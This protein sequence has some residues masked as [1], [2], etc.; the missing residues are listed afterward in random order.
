MRKLTLILW[1]AMMLA[2]AVSWSLQAQEVIA[3]IRGTVTDPSGAGIPGATVKATNT[4]TQ[5]STTVPSMDDGGFEFLSLTPGIYDVT[6]TKDGFRTFT[7]NKIT[8][9]L[10]QIYNLAVPM[11]VGQITESVQVE[12]N[13]AQVESTVTQL[14]TLITAQ[15]IV[16][17]PLIGRNWTTLE[18]LAP[19]V[20]ASSDRF[21][22]GAYATNG[23]QT[24]QNSFLIDGADSN[25]IAINTPLVIPSPD[26]I[27]EF[28]LVS[29]TMN[30][31]YGRNSGGILNAIIKSGTN[32]FHGSAFE[33]FRDTSLNDP[34]F[35]NQPNVFHQNEFGGTI[36]GPI[37]KDKT[38]FFLSYQ[39]Y[40]NREAQSLPGG[41][42]PTVFTQAQRNGSFPDIANSTT[43]SPIA[44]VA[45]SGATMAAGTPYNVL[46]PNGQI[47]AADF[48]AISANLLQKYVPLPN[49][50]GNLY[51]YSPVSTNSDYQGIAKVDQ[52]FGSKD[53]VWASAFFEDNP[54]ADTLS[55]GGGNLP[56][57]GDV[58]KFAL[59]T[60]AASWSHVFS[61]T[62][63]NEFRASYVRE[64]F[65]SGEPQSSVLPS[66]LGFTGINPQDPA[67]AGVPFVGITG[68][69]NLGFGIQGPVPRVDENYQLNESVSKVM[70]NHTLKFGFTGERFG[71]AE[72]FDFINNGYYTFG[73]AGLYST[74]DP[75]ADFLLGIPDSYEQTSG[76]TQKERAYEYY[77]FVQDSWKATRSLTLNYGLGYQIDTP[78]NN[79]WDGGLA[80]DCLRPGQQST[81]FPSAPVGLVF[82][83][84]PT[85]SS[86]GYYSHYDNFAPRF[87]FA[88]SPNWGPIS[89]GKAQ[90]FVIRGG[91]GISFNQAEEETALQ[92]LLSVPFALESLGI[93]DAG[94]NPSFAAPYTDIATGQSIPNKF[95]FSAPKPGNSNVN[96]SFFEPI[97]MNT[98]SPN[99]TTPYAMNYNLNIQRELPAA[100]VLQ[101]G[102]VGSQGRHLEVAYEGNP[103]TPAGQAACAA[104]QTCVA[105]RTLQPYL[106]PDHTEFV[107]GNIIASAGTQGT[108][109]VSNYN[110]L[111]ISANKRLTR[112]LTFTAAYTWS[113]SIDDGSGYEES[114]AQAASNPRGFNVY[115]AEL[116][117]GD[118][119]FDARHRF[120]ASY[121]YE[122]PHL[123]WN[124]AFVKYAVNGWRV[125]GI[126]TFQTGFPLTPYDSSYLSLTCSV[127]TYYGCADGP[128]SVG[129]TQI[130]N[131]R[132]TSLSNT[133][134]G[135]GPLPNYYFNPNSF[136]EQTPGTF[137]TSGRNSIH[138]PGINNTNLSLQKEIQFT[139]RR[140]IQLRLEA[141]NVFNH[142]QF[143]LPGNNIVT[144]NFGRVTSASAGRLIQLG[145]KFYF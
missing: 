3:H 135:T 102:Y 19:G 61:P 76:N 34:N 57:F 131:P 106:Y 100:I 121:D 114:S 49:S 41:S 44:L 91:F 46:F 45:E 126:T 101:V 11:E 55:F 67:A 123:G 108:I 28:N 74:G 1:G 16:D 14:G 37:R 58:N 105:N 140:K 136:T 80:M 127:F 129:P 90:K 92:N 128:N 89:G 66:S 17:M 113:H 95:P 138:G 48:N 143:L 133:V 56:G 27:Q 107:P 18:Q 59:K 137:G 63:L 145:A 71:V 75:A 111:Q 64:N 93:G 52:H 130:Y 4:Q 117:K 110:S 32:E 84:D 97:V 99:F 51:S 40:Y 43:A 42:L 21:G 83:G 70:G 38:F 142:A 86:S 23:S 139:E 13:L 134:A 35:F 87:G 39:G 50:P 118:S 15:Q 5:V 65:I 115:N 73:G 12:G 88:Y 25:D 24:Q 96:F 119:A 31:E 94:G 8:L 60:Y 7:A 54:S 22:S 26:A 120:V 81:V 78:F 36:G 112:R 62:T 125:A 2:L 30:A 85:C 29:S 103:I 82:P 33:F 144:P 68:Y 98:V 104:D 109:G 124:N 77:M 122:L 116:S 20:Q 132:N 72:K 79:S 69:F 9:A 53:T 141:Y 47:P 6:V 10:N